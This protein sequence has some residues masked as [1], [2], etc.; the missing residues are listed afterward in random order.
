MN[1]SLPIIQVSTRTTRWRLY[2]VQT[3]RVLLIALLLIAI[4]KPATEPRDGLV[5]PTVDELI[6]TGHSL[7]PDCVVGPRDPSSGLWRLEDVK[8]NTIGWV[9]RTFPD[10]QHAIGYRGPTEASILLNNDLRVLSVRLLS[11]EDTDEHV[12][13][14]SGS[15]QFFEHFSGLD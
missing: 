1:A 15:S 14:V 10:A 11:S 7:P 6:N 13:A 4:P 8:G 3:L 2:L 5:P 12:E 9:A